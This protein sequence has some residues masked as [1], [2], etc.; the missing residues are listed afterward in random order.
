M[1][2][3]LDTPSL[4]LSRKA[5]VMDVEAASQ[6]PHM[7][8]KNARPRSAPQSI[9]SIIMTRIECWAVDAQRKG[10]RKKE[11]ESKNEGYTDSLANGPQY[12]VERS[13]TN[14]SAS[15]IIRGELRK[16][17]RRMLIRLTSC[18][19]IHLRTHSTQALHA[20]GG[21]HPGMI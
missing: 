14:I 13:I 2:Q 8:A 19:E 12:V 4:G 11:D 15:K 1:A 21:T 17:L 9:L 18:H 20:G 5:L 16:V 7:L 10:E 3:R 6:L